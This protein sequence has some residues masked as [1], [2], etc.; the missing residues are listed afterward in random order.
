MERKHHLFNIS[1]PSHLRWGTHLFSSGKRERNIILCINSISVMMWSLY[2]KFKIKCC[3]CL[4]IPNMH[5]ALPAATGGC[6]TSVHQNK[7]SSVQV[8]VPLTC[9]FSSFVTLWFLFSL[10]S[11]CTSS[12]LPPVLDYFCFSVFFSF[13]LTTLSCLK[14]FLISFLFLLS[15]SQNQ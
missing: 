10:L 14:V 12:F 4:C 11:H 3:V 6:C 7:P 1:L 15:T 9:L 13:Y 2:I 5:A 8:S